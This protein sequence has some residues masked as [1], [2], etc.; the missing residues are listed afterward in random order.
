[1]SDIK[2]LIKTALDGEGSSF[3]DALDAEI[4]SRITDRLDTRKEEIASEV[5]GVQSEEEINESTFTFKST[6][7]ASKF[8]KAAVQA[9]LDKKMYKSKGKSV[10]VN[11]LK[12]VDLQQ[13]FEL[14]AKDMKAKIS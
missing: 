5:L 12:D 2:K 4:S 3:R 6:G 13:M 8:V 9:G 11:K 14:I 7:D 10:E 1:M